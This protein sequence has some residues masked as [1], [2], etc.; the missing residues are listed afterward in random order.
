MVPWLWFILFIFASTVL[1][2]VV[3]GRP[4]FRFPSWV[5]WIATLVME[6]TSLRRTCPTQRHRFLVMTVSISS[7]WHR[8]S[9]V[10]VTMAFSR[11]FR[12]EHRALDLSVP[13][14][15]SVCCGFLDLSQF[16]YAGGVHC[17]FC[18]SPLCLLGFSSAFLGVQGFIVEPVWRWAQV[19][20]APVG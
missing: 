11:P 5:Q 17:P 18:D 2:Q 14:V 19:A 1:R 13:S 16:F 8:A 7:C 12:V 10:L 4:H 3:F 6:L 15:I 9:N 20:F